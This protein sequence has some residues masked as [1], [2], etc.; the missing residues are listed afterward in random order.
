MYVKEQTRSSQVYS[1]SNNQNNGDLMM[2]PKYMTM[3]NIITIINMMKRIYLP[4]ENKGDKKARERKKIQRNRNFRKKRNRIYCRGC[5]VF[6][7][8]FI[9]E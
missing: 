3:Q 7:L 1:D 6:L 8:Y 2:Q 4:E 5:H 9:F